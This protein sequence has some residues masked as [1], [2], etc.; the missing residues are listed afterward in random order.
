MR[1]PQLWDEMLGDLVGWG[2]LETAGGGDDLVLGPGIFK[3]IK[4]TP[5]GCYPPL[6]LRHEET[7]VSF[8]HGLSTQYVVT[9]L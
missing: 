8:G 1:R 3:V 6:D 4:T 7:K 2:N 5:E 9:H